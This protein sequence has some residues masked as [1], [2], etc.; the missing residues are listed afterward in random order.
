MQFVLHMSKGTT[1]NNIIF[2]LDDVDSTSVPT[3][4]PSSSIAA[5]MAT[6]PASA[7]VPF[8]IYRQS[9]PA[10]VNGLSGWIVNPSMQTLPHMFHPIFN[11]HQPFGTIIDLDFERQDDI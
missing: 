1:T 9:S 6:G 4:F 10:I 8:G 5:N 11:S 2:I 7:A 3:S